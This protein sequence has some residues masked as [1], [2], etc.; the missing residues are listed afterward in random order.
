MF[1]RD[2]SRWREWWKKQ[3]GRLPEV[4]EPNSGLKALEKEIK[5]KGARRQKELNGGR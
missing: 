2:S 3:N 4:K 1:G 5:E